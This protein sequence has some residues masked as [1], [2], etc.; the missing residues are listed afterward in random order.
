MYLHTFLIL[1]LME[2]FVDLTERV[3]LNLGKEI[4]VPVRREAGW[5][6]QLFHSQV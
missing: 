2:L 3:A 6:P 1:A 4:P 5:F